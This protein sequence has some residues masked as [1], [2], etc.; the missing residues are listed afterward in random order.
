MMQY[1]TYFH[2]DAVEF[3]EQMTSTLLDWYGD[4]LE[5][6]LEAIVSEVDL[7]NETLEGQLTDTLPEDAH[8][9]LCFLQDYYRV[10]V[11]CSKES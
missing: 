3:A 6:A 4:D 8:C 5:P 10:A 2:V 1:T 9:L 7:M 11:E